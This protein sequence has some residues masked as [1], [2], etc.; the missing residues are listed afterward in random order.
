LQRN[1]T[2]CSIAQWTEQNFIALLVC[3]TLRDN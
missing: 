1:Y 3:S 2:A